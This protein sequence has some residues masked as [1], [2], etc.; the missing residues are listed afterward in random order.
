MG[1]VEPEF[2]DPDVLISAISTGADVWTGSVPDPLLPAR[3]IPG[4]LGGEQG[5]RLDQSDGRDHQR[6]DSV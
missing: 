5:S 1:N 2:V 6:D 4:V 3:L